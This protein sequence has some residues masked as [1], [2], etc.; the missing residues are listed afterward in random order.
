MYLNKISTNGYDEIFTKEHLMKDIQ[1]YQDDHLISL[2]S[3]YNTGTFNLIELPYVLYQYFVKVY[4]KLKNIQDTI[5]SLIGNYQYSDFLF[6]H[7]FQ[8]VQALTIVPSSK[9]FYIK[10]IKSKIANKT[11][12]VKVLNRN[13]FYKEASI[14]ESIFPILTSII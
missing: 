8:N 1:Y 3:L 10:D 5:N 13:S 7:Y 14:V 6:K 11:E 4:S 2:L 12:L 9:K